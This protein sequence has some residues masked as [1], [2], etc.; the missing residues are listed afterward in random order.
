MSAFKSRRDQFDLPEGIT[1][2]DGNSLEPA[3]IKGLQAS[4][5]GQTN[6]R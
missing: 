2:L 3:A 6:C 4:A 1:Y 5:R